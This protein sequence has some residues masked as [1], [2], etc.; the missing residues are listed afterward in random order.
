MVARLSG[1]FGVM[2]LVLACI[3]LYGLL[4]YEVSRRTREIGIRVALGAQQRD[5]LR[6]VVGLGI[7]LA[8]VGA[9]VGIG[10]ALA[11][12]RYLGSMLYDVHANDPV[13]TI[14]AAVL[15][16][17]VAIAASYIP[18]GRATPVDPMVALSY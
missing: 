3:G 16:S 4:S 6:L 18:A 13:T 7:L 12:T 17:L 15:L 1:F 2:A 14:A 11:V 5:V 8:I 10:V 9:A